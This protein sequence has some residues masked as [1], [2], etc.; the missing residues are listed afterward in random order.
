P[1]VAFSTKDFA[2]PIRVLVPLL[3]GI[4][5]G[6]EDFP[7]YQRFTAT[8]AEVQR[9]LQAV[10]P[11]ACEPA[12]PQ[13]TEILSFAVGWEK[14]GNLE[15]YAFR[16]QEDDTGPFYENL[17]ASLDETNLAGRKLVTEQF[18][19][20][21]TWDYKKGVPKRTKVRDEKDGENAMGN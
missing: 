9:I 10:K 15:G 16:I 2:R 17:I 21:V 11:I 7:S 1:P 3:G 5:V 18:R 14:E 19:R 4:W 20:V 13:N 8:A 12:G 6:D